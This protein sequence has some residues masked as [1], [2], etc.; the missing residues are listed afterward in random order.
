MTDN[1]I[2]TDPAS[3]G[4]FGGVLKGVLDGY[5]KS[6]EGQLPAMVTAYDRVRNVATVRPIITI[7]T[8]VG[9]QI[10]RPPVVEVPVLALGG[11]GFVINFPVKVGDMGW[12][13]ASD[14]DISLF[15]QAMREAQ[16]NTHRTHS[17]S[18][19]R[20]IPDVFG[21]YT[22][23]EED[24]DYAMVISSYDGAT[25]IALSPGKVKIAAEE[26]E[27]VGATK[28]TGS[29]IE[30]VGPVTITGGLTVDDI[31]FGTHKHSGVERGGSISDGPL[32]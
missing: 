17:F 26:V 24:M 15:K 14:R 25:R 8:T 3:D 27:I 21:A 30:L 18:D 9:K 12:I 10:P 22:I 6:V 31:P 13:E 28:I 29:S 19:G 1:V 4:S 11:G 16:P 23:N 5:M 32:A 20:F 7:V 2:S